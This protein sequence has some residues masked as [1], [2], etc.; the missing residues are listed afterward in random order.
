MSTL[1]LWFAIIIVSDEPWMGALLFIVAAAAAG[2][3]ALYPHYHVID[4]KGI[5]IYYIFL[6][7]E[8]YRWKDIK[9]V[10]IEYDSG[11]RSFPYMFDTFCIIGHGESKDYFFMRSEI[12]RS[13]KARKLIEHY[14]GKRIEGF[15]IDGLKED[16]RNLKARY[17]KHF[18][19]KSAIKALEKAAEGQLKKYC[20]MQG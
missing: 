15:M 13:R 1:S 8:D 7:K 17:R 19:D 10:Y 5:R 20:P 12:T 2:C 18:P 16:I 9:K 3:I 4:D 14:T 6:L 11:Y